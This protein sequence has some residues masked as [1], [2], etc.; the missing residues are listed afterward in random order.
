MAD[1]RNACLHKAK[2]TKNDEF[3][4][5]IE[6]IEKEMVH[7]TEHFKGKVIYCPC[8]DYRI[9]NFVKYFKNNFERHGLKKLIATNYDIGEGAFVYTYDG[10]CEAVFRVNGNGDYRNYQEYLDECDIVIT[11]PPFS[12][13]RD[14][15][16]WL[17]ENKKQFLIIGTSSV[18]HYKGFCKKIIE[19]ELRLGYSR[20]TSGKCFFLTDEGLKPISNAAWWTNM[21]SLV[22]GPLMLTEHYDPSAYPAYDNHP[23]IIECKYVRKIPKD[24]YGKIGV[25]ETFLNYWCPDQFDIL[26]MLGIG[27]ESRIGETA[28]VNGKNVYV[29]YVIRRKA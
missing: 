16:G 13:W 2:S 15:A 10:K 9:S 17:M 5:L 6:D 14:F 8:D 4:T 28:K 11:N 7:Y 3:Y 29:R 23:D 12:K 24:Y 20:R 26:G 22:R 18:I 1:R 19:G 25:P 27:G 21:P